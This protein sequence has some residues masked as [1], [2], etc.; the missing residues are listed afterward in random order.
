[1][2]VTVW[3]TRVGSCALVA[4]GLAAAALRRAQV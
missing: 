1:M 4:M 2:D 3:L